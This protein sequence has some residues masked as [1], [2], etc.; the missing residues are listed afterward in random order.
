MRFLKFLLIPL[1]LA[2]AFFVQRH[3]QASD[4]GAKLSIG[5]SQTL[6]A[7]GLLIVKEF[8][9]KTKIEFDIQTK[10]LSS[11]GGIKGLIEG[12]LDVARSSRPLK[13]SELR[14]AAEKGDALKSYQI[15]YGAIAI[16]MSKTH[17]KS[18]GA[19]SLA[20]LKD[21]FF[22]GKVKDWKQLD[23]GQKGVIKVIVNQEEGGSGTLDVFKEKVLAEEKLEFRNDAIVVKTI[24]DTLKQLTQNPDGISFLSLAA[25]PDKFGIAKLLSLSG[26]ETLCSPDGIRSGQYP[27]SRGLFLVVKQKSKSETFEFIEFATSAPGQSLMKAAG[28]IPVREDI[29]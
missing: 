4:S 2:A 26:Q 25:V 22:T 14:L 11:G 20:Q 6:E 9:Q 15:G 28:F 3:S 1:G 10:D 13:G 19:L 12:R 7:V 23:P 18:L 17:A 21:I 8:S 16:V 27:L 5:G 29:Q 24:E